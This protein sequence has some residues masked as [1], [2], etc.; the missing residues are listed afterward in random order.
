[1]YADVTLNVAML[2]AVS[3][4]EGSDTVAVVHYAKMWRFMGQFLVAGDQVR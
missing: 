3:V 4:N 2:Q 1:M